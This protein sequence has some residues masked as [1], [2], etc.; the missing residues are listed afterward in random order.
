[1]AR[2]K[3]TAGRNRN[4]VGSVRKLREGFF[5]GTIQLAPGDRRYVSGHT[6]QEAEEK[7]AKLRVLAQQG[8]LPVKSKQTV[9][10]YL[11]SWL[12][13]DVKQSVAPRTYE[14]YELNVRRLDP[15]IGSVRL[16]A[17]KPDNIKA[18][19]RELLQNGLSARSVQQTHRTLRAALR[20]AVGSEYLYRDPTA[21]VTPPRADDRDDAVLTPEQV[22]LLLSATSDHYLHPLWVVLATTG[23]R[24]GEALGLQWRDIDFDQGMLTIQRQAQRQQG[25]GMVLSGL[26]TAASRRSL[27]LPTGTIETLRTQRSTQREQ[28]AT[29]G[30]EWDENKQVFGGIDNRLLDPGSINK[31]FHRALARAGLPSCRVHD[32]RHTFSSF[33]QSR[34]RTEREAQE[35]LGHASASTTRNVYTHVM[36][37]RRRDILLP[38]EEFFL[39]AAQEPVSGD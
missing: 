29:L 30:T 1:M 12:D 26:K 37:D 33:I 11:R 34:G 7:L 9:S 32:L 15:L 14:N 39:A 4:G 10:Q 21:G 13:N 19:Y 22:R 6:V 24:L 35:V 8:Q 3:Q 5:Q 2:K 25:V 27:P 18:A 20:Q 38:V 28:F 17:L 16:D 23:M 31:S 36:P